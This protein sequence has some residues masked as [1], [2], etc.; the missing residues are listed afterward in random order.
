MTGP[1]H[2]E[3]DHRSVSPSDLRLAIVLTSHKTIPDILSLELRVCDDLAFESES[4]DNLPQ[5]T[6]EAALVTVGEIVQHAGTTFELLDGHKSLPQ[7]RVT[8]SEDSLQTEFPST[9]SNQHSDSRL[10]QDDDMGFLDHLQGFRSLAAKK[11]KVIPRPSEGPKFPS[12]TRGLVNETD[13]YASIPGAPIDLP[14]SPESG[15]PGRASEETQMRLFLSR[16]QAAERRILTERS[17]SPLLPE[18]PQLPTPPKHGV[19]AVPA[20]ITP[21]RR[22]SVRRVSASPSPHRETDNANVA[23]ARLGSDDV[24]LRELARPPTTG[25]DLT[26]RSHLPER[27]LFSSTD[28]FTT[29]ED[30][31]DRYAFPPCGH[32]TRS[33]SLEG[34]FANDS[35]DLS[36]DSESVEEHTTRQGQTDILHAAAGPPPQSALP[37]VPS[38]PPCSALHLRATESSN[39]ETSVSVDTEELLRTESTIGVA[40]G[41][42]QYDGDLSQDFMT[43]QWAHTLYSRAPG[44]AG[45][46]PRRR[47]QYIPENSTSLQGHASSSAAAQFH[48]PLCRRLSSVSENSEKSSPVNHN[49]TLDYHDAMRDIQD[50][51]SSLENV[52]ESARSR[53]L[54]L[55][56]F[57]ENDTP[58]AQRHDSSQ[59]R[60]LAEPPDR[61]DRRP[62]LLPSPLFIEDRASR[63]QGDTSEQHEVGRR[64]MQ[65]SVA[66]NQHSVDTDFQVM[67]AGCSLIAKDNTED[68][69]ETT[70]IRSSGLPAGF[71]TQTAFVRR[72]PGKDLPNMS[73]HGST[74]SQ[75]LS[76]TTWDALPADTYALMHPTKTAKTGDLQHRSNII[77]GVKLYLPEYSPQLPTSKKHTELAKS[78]TPRPATADLNILPTLKILVPRDQQPQVLLPKHMNSAASSLSSTTPS[79]ALSSTSLLNPD[80][81]VTKSATTTRRKDEDGAFPPSTIKDKSTNPQID[82]PAQVIAELPPFTPVMGSKDEDK[83]RPGHQ[84]DPSSVLSSSVLSNDGSYRS[85]GESSQDLAQF[86][87]E[88]PEPVRNPKGTFGKT[89]ILGPQGNLTGTLRGTGMRGLGSSLAGNSSSPAQTPRA[90]MYTIEQRPDSTYCPT[91]PLTTNQLAA[92]LVGRDTPPFERYETMPDGLFF[93]KAWCS[94]HGRWEFSHTAIMKDKSKTLDSEVRIIQ[95]TLGKRMIRLG[96]FVYPFGGFL[97]LRD[98]ERNGVYAADLMGLLSGETTREIHAEDRTAAGLYYEAGLWFVVAAAVACWALF[99]LAL[100]NWL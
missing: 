82:Y 35:D 74:T 61:V 39:S 7:Y 27:G 80:M 99:V 95:R 11:K 12:M 13:P 87:R 98:M 33:S 38:A 43:T 51:S 72:Q 75:Q 71:Y 4:I 96:L 52:S 46:G 24:P 29:H 64:L 60:E 92:R 44:V 77:T 20:N 63:A 89:T 22:A 17:N 26:H 31:I 23:H 65:R 69:W 21:R 41:D 67:R 8:S 55:L 37:P 58:S 59:Q 42:P 10:L 5:D 50:R 57:G 25:G 81:D 91:F 93:E 48:Q 66:R 18:A 1:Q 88:N 14:A 28:A 62:S 40:L 32:L 76:T 94:R 6:E 70:S 56:R 78:N 45:N 9:I 16:Q 79:P 19:G 100:V 85:V 83:N 3:R 34:L 47:Q 15:L 2:Q 73:R 68:E 90:V 30:F 49:S 36:A 53:A 97:L 84:R 86:L 54:E